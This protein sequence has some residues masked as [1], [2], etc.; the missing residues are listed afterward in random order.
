MANFKTAHVKFDDASYNYSRS[1]NGNQTD[2]QIETFFL[3]KAIN[4]GTP[5]EDD[6][7]ICTEIEIEPVIH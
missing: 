5:N 2:T 4:M 3:F 7:Q 1:V 6:V